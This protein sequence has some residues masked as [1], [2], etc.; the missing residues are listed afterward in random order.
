MFCWLCRPQP[1]EKIKEREEKITN[2]S[3]CQANCFPDHVWQFSGERSRKSINAS[4]MLMRLQI[5][6]ASRFQIMKC[7]SG[8]KSVDK[9]YVE[10]ITSQ[11][12]EY[13]MHLVRFS[14]SPWTP[15]NNRGKKNSYSKT[16]LSIPSPSPICYAWRGSNLE[17]SHG[18]IPYMCVYVCFPFTLSILSCKTGIPEGL[19]GENWELER[20]CRAFRP[21]SLLFHVQCRLVKP[22]LLFPQKKTKQQPQHPQGC[23]SHIAHKTKSWFCMVAKAAIL[24]TLARK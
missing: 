21:H 13:F 18:T 11:K 16:C 9:I 24:A 23:P 20:K 22:I 8:D 5:C 12:S 14:R 17:S 15:A 2:M 3:L 10:N 7:L 19:S 1:K 6:Q 4:A